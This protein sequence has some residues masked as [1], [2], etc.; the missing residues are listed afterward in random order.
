MKKTN[1][2]IK[3]HPLLG[4]VILAIIIIELIKLVILAWILVEHYGH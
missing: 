3:Q 2:L 1:K 4:V